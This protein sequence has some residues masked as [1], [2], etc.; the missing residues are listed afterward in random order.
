M[1]SPDRVE[2]AGVGNEALADRLGGISVGL[3]LSGRILLSVARSPTLTYTVDY[4]LIYS[5]IYGELHRG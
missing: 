1:V 5:P 3:S 2:L 4:I